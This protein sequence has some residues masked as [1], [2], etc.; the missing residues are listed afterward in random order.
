MKIH[1][2][3]NKKCSSNFPLDGVAYLPWISENSHFCRKERNSK[4]WSKNFF[5]SPK[6]IRVTQKTPKI[7]LSTLR[8]FSIFRSGDLTENG[9][10]IFVK[11]MQNTEGRQWNPCTGSSPNWIGDL[12]QRILPKIFFASTLGPFFAVTALFSAK[13][14]VNFGQMETLQVWKTLGPWAQRSSHCWASVV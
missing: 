5:K 11:C 10:Y 12:Y 1:S 6:K 7:V 14:V 3:T 9:P 8:V 4:K 2:F 13:S